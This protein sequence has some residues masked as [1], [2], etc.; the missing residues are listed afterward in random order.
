MSASAPMVSVI[1]PLYN[2]ERH[3]PAALDSVLGQTFTDFEI[4]AVDD[5]SKDGTL[6]ILR[7]YEERDSRL[8]VVSRP[9]TG[10]VGALN[11]GLA[12]ARGEFIARMDGDDLCLPERF[13]RQID[14]LRNNPQ[15]VLVGSQ[16]LLI[17]PDGA[18]ICPHTQ[19]RFSHEEIDHDHLNRGWP[20]I[21]PSVM[22][23]RQAVEKVGG[24]R[25]E[26]KWLEDH[27][28]FLRLAE[29]G[30]LANLP[31]VLL[32][33]RL[34]FQSVCHTRVDIQGPLKQ[35]LYEETRKRR[36]AAA[37]DGAYKLP[38]SRSESE[39]HRMW[40]WWALKA[41]N[42]ATARKHALKTVAHAPFSGESWR[43]MACAVRGH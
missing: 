41:G 3:L 12:L 39:V 43:I 20:V 7:D 1:M 17:D 4:I 9:N 32:K 26:Y 34:H 13:A 29:I 16:V 19:T 31:E 30:C 8:R 22:M 36:G 14:H 18:P 15:C 10:I 42:V 2:T 23:R 35:K 40:A 33:Y 5:G 6:A 37:A 11:D 27:D 21:H 25:E 28:L 38:A 24:Y